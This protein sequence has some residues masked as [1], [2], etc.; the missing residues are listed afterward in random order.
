M[1]PD[2]SDPTQSSSSPSVSEALRGLNEEELNA[3]S[4]S[5]EPARHAA[6]RPPYP[7]VDPSLERSPELPTPS[8][9]RDSPP[10]LCSTL[11]DPER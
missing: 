4:R 9:S 5:A 8:R 11:R 7:P 10:Y 3:L 2:S 1:K 6:W